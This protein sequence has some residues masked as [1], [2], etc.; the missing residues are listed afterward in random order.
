MRSTAGQRRADAVAAGMRIFADH[1][2]TSTALQ[3]V[4]DE[5]GVSQPYVFRLFGTKRAF[6]LA[7]IDE[8]QQRVREVLRDAV[9]A[10]APGDELTAMRAGFRAML[11]D[12]VI[13]GLWLQACAVAR[14]DAAVAARCRDLISGVLEEAAR[15]SE[16]SPDRVEQALADGVLIMML[17]AIGVDLAGGSRAAIGSLRVKEGEA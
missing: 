11:A 3:R 8:M 2:P 1:G 5:I 15:L 12:G 17:Q 9:S 6:F 16:E 14:W 4:A 10:V 13:S 7:C